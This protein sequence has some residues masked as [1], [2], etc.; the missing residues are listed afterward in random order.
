MTEKP[1]RSEEEYFAK[2]EYEKLKSLAEAKTREMAQGE[3]ERL[4][5]L[6]WMHC[7]KCGQDLVPVKLHGVEVDR[8]PACDGLWLD[9]GELGQVLQ[10]EGG[11]ALKKL[12]DIFKG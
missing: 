10:R 11:S 12:L 8:C 1:S 9:A 6:H 3:K 5:E 2:A 4:K 7:P